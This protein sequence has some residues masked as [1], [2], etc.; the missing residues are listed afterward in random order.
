MSQIPQANLLPKAFSSL[1]EAFGKIPGVGARTAERYAYFIWK[2]DP[3]VAGNLAE[4][5]ADLH[6]SIKLCPKTF[7]LISEDE[8]TSPLYY[9][10]DRDKSQVL[11]V[12]EP[13]DIV[14]IEK[15]GGYTGT[16]H[17]LGGAISPIDN[18]GP[19]QLKIGELIERIAEDE[20]REVIVATNASIEGESTAIYLARLIR[21]KFPEVKTSRLA[22]GIPI[23]VDLEYADSLTLSQALKGRTEI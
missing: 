23:G 14:A 10:T 15:T 21:E 9:I 4:K 18:V 19:E 16:Y 8:D 17:C 7:A 1:I 5:L 6:S 20:V 3:Q 22:R 12:E 13:L 2:A 11:V